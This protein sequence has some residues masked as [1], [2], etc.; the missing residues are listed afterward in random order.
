MAFG[1]A[2]DYHDD[3]VDE[4]SDFKP[5]HMNIPPR[6]LDYQIGVH[7]AAIALRLQSGDFIIDDSDGQ[8][9]TDDADGEPVVDM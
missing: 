8:I 4:V 6:Q 1:Q 3:Y 2:A 5:S 7:V 9:V